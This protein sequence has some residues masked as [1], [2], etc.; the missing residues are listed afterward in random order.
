[1]GNNVSKPSHP[2]A[3]W[4]IFLSEIELEPMYLMPFKWEQAYRSQFGSD[5]LLFSE[6]HPSCVSH[7]SM[8]QCVRGRVVF[9]G[10]QVTLN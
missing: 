8:Q 6:K 7:H 9:R 10:P 5:R 1:M 4:G 3:V 2:A